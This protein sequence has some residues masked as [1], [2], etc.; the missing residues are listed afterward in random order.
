MIGE[1]LFD[2]GEDLAEDL[3]D[4]WRDRNRMKTDATRRAIEQREADLRRRYGR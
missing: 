4:D 1:T 2:A 3:Y